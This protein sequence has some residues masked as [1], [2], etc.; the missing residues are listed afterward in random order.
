M[1]LVIQIKFKN[2][3][4]KADLL[5]SSFSFFMFDDFGLIIWHPFECFGLSD[6][7]AINYL[8]S[9]LIVVLIN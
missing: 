7:A 5:L 1:L 8:V 2:H 3:A 4:F 9:I 6:L